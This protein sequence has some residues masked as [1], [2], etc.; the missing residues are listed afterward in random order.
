MKAT[1]VH[2]SQAGSIWMRNI[3]AA[4]TAELWD[5]LAV[6][7]AED[8]PVTLAKLMSLVVGAT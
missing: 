8:L 1:A 7:L 3:L 5:G 4:P 6:V 2:L